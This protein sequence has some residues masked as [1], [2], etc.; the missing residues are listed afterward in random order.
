MKL[1]LLFL[2]LAAPALTQTEHP[3]VGDELRE[4]LGAL[5]HD[6]AKVGRVDDVRLLTRVLQDVGEPLETLSHARLRWLRLAEQNK[7]KVL[8]GATAQRL[9]EAAR[10][11][12]GAWAP[13]YAQL[14][15]ED[16]ARLARAV[17]ALDEQQDSAHEVLG[18]TRR[19]ARWL[20]ADEVRSEARTAQLR[21]ARAAA[22]KVEVTFEVE[23]SDAEHLQAQCG[24]SAV[25]V[26]SDGIVVHSDLPAEQVQAL[27]TEVVRAFHY[28]GY[29]RTGQ[30]TPV[31]ART[32]REFVLLANA[33]DFP[34]FAGTL[35][36]AGLL[37]PHS[38]ELIA[39]GAEHLLDQNRRYV[40]G[41]LSPQAFQALLLYSLWTKDV[42]TNVQP[43][44][45][46][47]HLNG[48]CIDFFSYPC[49]PIFATFGGA[50]GR[51]ATQGRGRAGI[52]PESAA[53]RLAQSGLPESREFL[54]NLARERKDPPWLDSIEPREGVINDLDMLKCTWLVQYL[55]DHA[56]FAKLLKDTRS[57]RR[58]P[59]VFVD[60]LGVRLD[61]F[62]AEWRRWL[63]DEPRGLAQRLARQ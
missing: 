24:G 43:S 45:T 6:L 36:R 56:R 32:F 2:A 31:R 20:T 27:V 1:P 34:A 5:I 53:W 63:L 35:M 29:V 10:A 44:L 62:E 58:G 25:K 46:A 28:S 26:T 60:A 54:V 17:L 9:A 11:V 55:Q 49:P 40:G 57:G 51:T 39:Q 50:N 42:G 3:L 47:G 61:E 16:Q 38:M 14:A 37:A 22:D 19:G 8:P 4:P 18:H 7:G 15:A 23:R 48:I 52:D 12:A 41:W 30:L 59:D 13:L 21:K 33:E